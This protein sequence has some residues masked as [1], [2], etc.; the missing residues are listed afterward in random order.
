M[1]DQTFFSLAHL[2]DPATAEK[3]QALNA[4][5]LLDW[6]FATRNSKNAY[7]QAM[8]ERMKP[9]TDQLALIEF[10]VRQKMQTED[11]KTLA[12]AA[13]KATISERKGFKVVDPEAFSTY[14]EANHLTH[15]LSM[16]I[17]KKAMDE[18]VA[19]HGDESGSLP[20]PGVERTVSASIRFTSA[21]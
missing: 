14:I 15:L 16:T 11:V 19:E 3:L 7:E 12:A 1:T 21:K 10:L 5:Q 18:F 6:Y 17:D 13:G 4:N 8:I 2:D 20:I 9:L